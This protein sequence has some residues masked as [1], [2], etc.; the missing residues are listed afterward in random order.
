MTVRNLD[1]LFKPASV[2][3]IG[4]SA[5]P[6]S[7]GAVIARNLRGAGFAGPIMLVNPK[8]AEI[9]GEP[10]YPDPASLPATPD[11]AVV[12]T[13]PDTVPDI[14]AGLG[15]RGTK[16]VVVITAGFA[17]GGADRGRALQHAMLE[18]ARPHLLRIV[19]PNCFGIMV[20]GRGLDATFGHMT[21]KPGK[22]AFVTQ[23]GAIM[24]GIVDW[25]SARGIGFSH[26]VSV[27]DMA[28]VDFGDLLDYFAQDRRTSAIL[29]YMEAMT[30]ARKF[31]SAA[32]A[33]SRRK[34]VIVLKAGRHAEGARAVA[35]HTGALAGADAV[36]GA[37]FRRAGM[38][39]VRSLQDLFDAAEI[40]AT[41]ARVN[42]D[43]LS[44][45]SN[46]GG[47]GVLATD[48][49]ID[50]GG[51]LAELA[52][53]TLE[54]LDA[55]LPA[56]WS[57]GNPVDIIGDASGRRYADSLR[58][59]FEDPGMDAIV[60]LNCPTGTASS[61]DAAEAVVTAA[62]RPGHP[63]LIAS[64]VGDSPTVEQARRLLEANQVP[65]YDTPGQAV[66]AFM[67]LV[68]YRDSQRALME[69]P[70]SVPE[71]FVPD[72]A[73]A[74]A[75][76]DGA[77]A[78][79]RD[80]LTE[81]EAKELLAA[82]RIPVAKTRTV[83][84]AEEAMAA[85]DAIGFPVAVKVLSPDITH[86][87]DPGGVALDLAD[88]VQVRAAVEAMRA[89]IAQTAPQA[90]IEGFVV[91]PMIRRPNAQELI[92]GASE[93]PQFGLVILFGHGGTAVEIVADRAL[94]LPPLNMRLA[95]D[96]IEQ[97][98]VSRLLRGYRDRPPADLDAVA[99]TLI[100]VAQ[101]VVDLPEVA[102]L[103]INPLLADQAGVIALDARI[104][105]VPATAPAGRRLAIRPYPK[106]LE[107]EIKL[108]GGR[109]LLLRPIRPE[110]EPMLTAAFHKLSPQSVRLRFFASIK[111]LTHETAAGLT[112]IDYD[113]EMALVL[114]DDDRPGIAQLYAIARFSTD[115]DQEKA[116]FALT[117][118]DDVTGRGFGPLLMRRLI[119]YARERGI[120]EIFGHVLRENRSM[121]A[122]C[123]LLGF[124]ETPAPDDP[125]V[126][127]VRLPL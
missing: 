75:V 26:L 88:A 89:R 34:P 4:A 9:D 3:L 107:D 69:T 48:T 105:V 109:A 79:G 112:Q 40:L 125:Q 115:P 36:Y 62:Q 57:H 76:I 80:W 82:Y 121:L 16:A 117:V 66:L 83:A 25:A 96:L 60:A 87:S 8:H 104:R 12:V 49:L 10:S 84:D 41:S 111:D 100:K 31:M 120:R 91:Q 58:I 55:V 33:A 113:R 6:L 65:V 14:I 28:D 47:F 23:S 53:A 71:Q 24:T 70:P 93:D 5:Q 85:A 110:D 17:E 15:A 20:P 11:L 18:A 21:A 72:T 102:E 73:A 30:E 29:L 54:R 77:L 56:T 103:D 114:A 37:A 52:P 90:R 44:I 123:R 86:K 2:A 39:R 59:L 99:V 97:T 64:W 51:H 101:I 68:R 94:A 63:P 46:G 61:I 32:R 43:R 127:L 50:E 124:E 108:T 106:E 95:N 35:S 118:R 74:R 22:L 27:G 42:G 116:E 78:S 1:C 19:G 45:L 38:L 119:D 81:P 126:K 7:P 92:V 98:R 122:I 67:H 13:P